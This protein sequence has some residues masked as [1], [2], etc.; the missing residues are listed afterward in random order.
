[1]SISFWKINFTR[2]ETLPV[3]CAALL[4]TIRAVPDIKQVTDS[5][6]L[7]LLVCQIIIPIFVMPKIRVIE[8]N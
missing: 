8:N 7:N 2:I 3:V 5:L 1:M 6:R 4:P